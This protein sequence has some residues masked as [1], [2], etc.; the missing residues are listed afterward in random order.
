MIRGKVVMV[1]FPFD[2][3]STTKARP[4]VCLTEPVGP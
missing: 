1:P 3:L 2:D 4:V